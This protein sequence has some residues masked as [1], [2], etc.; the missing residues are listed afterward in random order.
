MQ[1]L[2][3]LRMC[4]TANWWDGLLVC[5]LHASSSRRV[6]FAHVDAIT[7]ER[8]SFRENPRSLSDAEYVVLFVER[9]MA[10][11]RSDWLTV[12]LGALRRQWWGQKMRLRHLSSTWR[13]RQFPGSQKGGVFFVIRGHS[14]PSWAVYFGF[15][16]LRILEIYGV[17]CHW[18]R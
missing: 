1:T 3:E 12:A 13:G 15:S 14:D 8:S 7:S 4:S 6:F 18:V 17:W 9:L 2:G 10:R 5:G 16:A 11:Y